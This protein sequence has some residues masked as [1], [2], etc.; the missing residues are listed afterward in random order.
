ML[1]SE[2]TL[3]TR[4]QVRSTALCRT[5]LGGE[6]PV[7][8]GQFST[9]ISGLEAHLFVGVN[10]LQAA[11]HGAIV[12]L[13]GLAQVRLKHALWKRFNDLLGASRRVYLDT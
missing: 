3:H 9:R 1:R 12:H 11:C 8:Q 5:I 2:V 13:E 4:F 6:R 7:R 10:S